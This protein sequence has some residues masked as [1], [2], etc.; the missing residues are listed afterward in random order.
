VGDPA[1]D[2]AGAVTSS[3]AGSLPAEAF[4]AI[5]DNTAHAF[6]VIDSTGEFRYVG[7][8]VERAIGWPPA[9]LLGRNM[10]E[11][12]TPEGVELALQTV[13]EID[14]TD[15]TGAGVPMVFQLAQPDGSMR[16]VEIGAIPLFDV[17]GVDGIALRLR[18]WSGQAQ[19][20]EFVTSLL[21]DDP[22]PEVLSRLCRSIATSLDGSGAAVHH[23]FDGTV[24]AAATGSGV[25]P[26]CL[27]EAGP[28]V[29]AAAHGALIEASV[30]ERPGS[31]R[32]GRRRSPTWRRW[33]RPPSR[34]GVRRRVAC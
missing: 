32:V 16:W 34:S 18:P 3:G 7:G 9:S 33:L 30:D 11:F 24:F 31:R 12:L 5:V 27:A 6:V 21:A 14:A 26:E 25:P 23:G 28:W 29:E 20:D 19:F 13:A 8:S 4:R 2:P 15:R 22:L 1:S 17:P 10:V